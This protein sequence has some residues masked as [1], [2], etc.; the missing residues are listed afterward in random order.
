MLYGRVPI[1]SPI[2]NFMIPF[3]EIFFPSLS[4]RTWLLF[5]SHLLPRQEIKLIISCG[6]EQVHLLALVEDL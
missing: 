6:S 5:S 2:M 3:I 1:T 4:S